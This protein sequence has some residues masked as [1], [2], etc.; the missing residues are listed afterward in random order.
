MT[1]KLD[2]P[3]FKSKAEEAEWWYRHREETTKWLEEALAAG[4]TTSLSAVLQRA[5]RAGSGPARASKGIRNT[6][7]GIRK[8][9]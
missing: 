2:I 6:G 8:S 5:R 4:Q 7:R 3:K 1:R 9:H